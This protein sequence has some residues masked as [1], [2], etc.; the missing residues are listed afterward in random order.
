M[1]RDKNGVLRLAKEGNVIEKPEDIIKQPTVDQIEL[2]L[3]KTK[4]GM[5]VAGGY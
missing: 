2:E 1:S 5:Y 4:I 3:S